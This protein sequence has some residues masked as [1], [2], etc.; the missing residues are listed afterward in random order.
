MAQPPEMKAR[1]AKN[2]DVSETV[3]KT[4]NV[5]CLSTRRS[6]CPRLN[7]EVTFT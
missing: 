4:A 1:A 2:E 5:K 6:V 3:R 7:S